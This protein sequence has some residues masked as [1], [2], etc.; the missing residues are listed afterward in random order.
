ME[1]E[2]NSTGICQ[3]IGEWSAVTVTCYPVPCGL[4]PPVDN[5]NVVYIRLARRDIV[6]IYT[7]DPGYIMG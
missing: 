2:D 3:E 1:G 6:A 5:S 7:C 4:T